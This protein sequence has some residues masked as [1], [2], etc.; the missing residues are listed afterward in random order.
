MLRL[1][2]AEP[3]MSAAGTLSPSS[4]VD[5]TLIV[6]AV[7]VLFSISYALVRFPGL[8]WHTG[9]RGCAYKAL[10]PES[11]PGDPYMTNQSPIRL[12]SYYV[13]VRLVGNLWLDDRFTFFVYLCLVVLALVCVDKTAQYFGAKRVGD[14]LLVISLM[15]IGHG[16]RDNIGDIVT[17]ADLYAG[18]FAGVAGIWCI[19]F[20]LSGARLWRLVGCLVLSWSLN[21]RWAWFPSVIA[22]TIVAR[23][24]LSS[25]QQRGLLVALVFS[26]LAGL[27]AYTRWLAPPHRAQF[28]DYLVRFDN[29][30][31]DPFLD[32][33]IANVKYWLLLGA[34]LLMTPLAKSAARQVRMI[35]VIGAS[36]W[37]FGGLYMNY[38]PEFLKVPPLVLLGFNRATQ[39]PQYVLFLSIAVGVVSR[40]RR[41][42]FSKQLL[43]LTV[44]LVLYAT[45][46]SL[47][48]AKVGLVFCAVFLT[49]C[50]V[51][52]LASR[53]GSGTRAIGWSG[54]W[55]LAKLAA[56]TFLLTTLLVHSR[57]I[58][59]RYPYLV[60]LARHG[61]VGDNPSAKWVGIDDYI[62]THTPPDAII[63]PIATYDYPWRM[64]LAYDTSLKT[65]SGRSVPIGHPVSVWFD[66][67][68]LQQE[69]VRRHHLERLM[70]AWGKRDL[71]VVRGELAY[72]KVGYLVVEN[73]EAA[74]LRG[75]PLEY[76]VQISLGNF[77]VFRRKDLPP[78]VS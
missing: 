65:R 49:S 12:S 10:H 59:K 18:T 28:F 69:E 58:I 3:D 14:R 53:R 52:R 77:T 8:E 33:P 75:Q 48:L 20:A 25:R 40:M 50:W 76:L 63:L 41:A 31:A 54:Q 24:R 26:L 34:G 5:R 27:L 43:L 13:L 29:S 22:L 16:F 38:S 67:E 39:W 2:R 57:T 11:F 21:V 68:K 56:L 35:A 61:V 17:S 55:D 1:P 36:L 42:R 46:D 15:A 7:I 60:Y 45:F 19:Y 71:D 73:S 23:E 44:L 66:Y 37:I 4:R 51:E 30:E 32:K 6:G 74:W 70:A 64:G 9:Y 78:T 62:R 72:F 47:K